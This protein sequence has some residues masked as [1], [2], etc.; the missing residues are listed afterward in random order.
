MFQLCIHPAKR[1]RE[2]LLSAIQGLLLKCSCTLKNSRLMLLVSLKIRW[3]TYLKQEVFLLFIKEN[4]MYVLKCHALWKS[5]FRCPLHN[6]SLV[7]SKWKVHYCPYAG[8]LMCLGCWWLRRGVG[9][10]TGVSWNFILVNWEKLFGGWCGSD[11]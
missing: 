7:F 11:F 10:C 4:E 1:V 2:G 8:V 6:I 3:L 9:S 5:R